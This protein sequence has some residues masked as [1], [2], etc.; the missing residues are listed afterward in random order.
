M[1]S[2]DGLLASLDERI[3][4]REIGIPLDE[5]RMRYMLR[6]NT[7]EDFHEFRHIIA[8]FTNHAQGGRLSPSE[9][10]GKGKELIE[11]DNRKRRGD[12]VS[13]FNNGHDGTHGG[14]RAILDIIAEGLKAEAVERY[15]SD[16]F[17]SHVTP[18][19]WE[20][21][22]EIIRQFIARCGAYLST[23]IKAEQPERYAHDYSGLI[24]SYV[25]GLQQTSSMF[26]RL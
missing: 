20:Q 4:A 13:A 25:D 18:N 19:S 12:I 10:Y 15:I 26:R 5:K 22:V 2:I 7:V 24:R 6:S 16:V 3:I 14:M 23:S 8:D 1:P 11:R 9:A 21:K 17:D